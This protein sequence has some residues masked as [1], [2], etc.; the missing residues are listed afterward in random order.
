MRCTLHPAQTT[1]LTC[2]PDDLLTSW[3]VQRH[4]HPARLTAGSMIYPGIF[5]GGRLISRPNRKCSEPL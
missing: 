3:R 5:S 4:R 2:M 1:Q